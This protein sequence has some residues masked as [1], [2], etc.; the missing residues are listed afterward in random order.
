VDPRQISIGI[1][2]GQGEKIFLTCTAT[3]MGGGDNE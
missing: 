2:E 1:T 3:Q